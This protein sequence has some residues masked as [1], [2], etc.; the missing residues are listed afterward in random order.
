MSLM[1]AT[2]DN[3]RALRPLLSAMKVTCS[4]G[5]E[6]GVQGTVF[7]DPGLSCC[8]RKQ[9]RNLSDLPTFANLVATADVV[10]NT[11]AVVMTLRT[12]LRGMNARVGAVFA[13]QRNLAGVGI[14][15]EMEFPDNGG[16]TNYRFNGWHN[17][18]MA[19]HTGA[20]ANFNQTFSIYFL[21]GFKQFPSL[22]RT[23][24]LIELIDAS[25]RTC[26]F[27][28]K[29]SGTHQAGGP[30]YDGNTCLL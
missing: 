12:K 19:R 7:T 11:N 29:R 10:Q 28:G 22:K 27:G 14:Q 25:M 5:G 20:L 18:L 26:A 8:N 13:V 6:K 21:P 17:G 15:A 3:F 9:P 23:P 2:G 24:G 1:S 16:Y 4:L 30:G